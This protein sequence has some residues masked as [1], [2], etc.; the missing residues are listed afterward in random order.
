[1]VVPVVDKAVELFPNAVAILSNS[2][3]SGDDEGFKMALETEALMKLPVIRHRMKK[4]GCLNEVSVQNY[5][6]H[7]TYCL[8]NERFLIISN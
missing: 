3:G 1:M 6:I 8:H 5:R 4:P 7:V 2:A